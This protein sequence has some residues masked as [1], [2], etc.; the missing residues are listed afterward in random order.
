MIEKVIT[1]Y[2]KSCVDVPVYMGEAPATKPKEY[3]VIELIDSGRI[4]MIDAVTFSFVSHST[5]LLKSAELNEE[6]KK[7]MYE[8]ISL[9]EVSSSKYGGG[10]PNINSTTKEYTYESIF[11]LFYYA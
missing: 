3:V 10:S 11:N 6:V 7:A 2:L 5:T 9:D 4:N 1:K 8:A